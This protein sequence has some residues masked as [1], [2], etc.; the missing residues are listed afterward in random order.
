MIPI[1]YAVAMGTGALGSLIFGRLLD[2]LGQQIILFVFFLSAL[3]APLVFFGNSV[4]AL[5]GMALWGLSMGAQDSILKAVLIPTIPQD[6]RSSAFGL[7]DTGF[8][9]AWFVGS[10]LMGLFYD[11]SI[12][13]LVV[14]SVILQLAALPLFVLA[15]RTKN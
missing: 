10:A 8:G 1:F 6:K 4:F 14:F 12:L 7:F 2:K 15:A 5:V 9:I 11:I 13:A 3:F